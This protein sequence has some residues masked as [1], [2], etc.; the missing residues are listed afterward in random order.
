MLFDY[1][2]LENIKNEMGD[3]AAIQNL[4]LD[5]YGQIIELL[6]EFSMILPDVKENQEIVQEEIN[7]QI[8]IYLIDENPFALFLQ[9]I[10]D[11]YM[12]ALKKNK[13]KDR[14]EY[15]SKYEKMS[16]MR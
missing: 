14:S 10:M 6:A 7:H 16:A 13:G 4:Q 1:F 2:K 11:K 8:I 9:R 3:S 12:I 15:V 5:K